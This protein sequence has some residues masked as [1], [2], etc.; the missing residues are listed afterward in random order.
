MFISR[1]CRRWRYARSGWETDFGSG[2]SRAASGLD[3]QKGMGPI[4]DRPL[5]RKNYKRALAEADRLPWSFF[6][7]LVFGGGDLFPAE[8]VNFQAFDD[9]WT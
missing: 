9:R 6:F 3:L 8:I 5:A 2:R 1:S 7:E 4:G